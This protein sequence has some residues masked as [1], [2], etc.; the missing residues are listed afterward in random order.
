MRKMH[1]TTKE[2]LEKI[3]HNVYEAILVMGQRSRQIGD[4]QKSILNKLHDEYQST[5]N[6]SEDAPEEPEELEIPAFTKPSVQALN[7]LLSG[8]IHYEYLDPE[9][10]GDE[11]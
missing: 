10:G 4:H 7:E 11:A 5:L 1:D 8:E 2:D 3:N 6:L 9:E